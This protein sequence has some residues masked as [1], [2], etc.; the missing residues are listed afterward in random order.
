[1]PYDN[2]MAT[3]NEERQNDCITY[4]RVVD[5]KKSIDCA[6]MVPQ[7][8]GA[9]LQ[10]IH[11]RYPSKCVDCICYSLDP[12]ERKV[13]YF[14]EL[15]I[16]RDY[17]AFAKL[18]KMTEEEAEVYDCYDPLPEFYSEFMG[19]NRHWV[20]RE[21]KFMYENLSRQLDRSPTTIELETALADEIIK[22]GRSHSKRFRVFYAIAFPEKVRKVKLTAREQELE[23]LKSSNKNYSPLEVSVGNVA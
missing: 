5:S 16:M 1:M 11:A 20:N 4:Q 18:K 15:E 2:Y 12:A 17:C 9:I 3:E 19:L 8:D 6:S 23:A 22:P 10:A 7:S 14:D 21:K 13:V